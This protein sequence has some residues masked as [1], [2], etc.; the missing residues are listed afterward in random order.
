MS[1][2]IYAP[3]RSVVECGLTPRQVLHI[4]L[5]TLLLLLF[6]MMLLRRTSEIDHLLYGYAWCR[7]KCAFHKPRWRVAESW[8]FCR[9]CTSR[10]VSFSLLRI[11]LCCFVVHIKIWNY[12][13]EHNVDEDLVSIMLQGGW[14]G[15]G[16]MVGVVNRN[17][18]DSPTVIFDVVASL[19]T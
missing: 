11:R 10:Y 18:N 13:D 16:N 9:C 15:F 8:E 5:W 12:T 17:M 14:W 19:K 3:S 1:T 4:E 2:K 7:R 6:T